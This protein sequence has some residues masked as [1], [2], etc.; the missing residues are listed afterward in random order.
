M[1][2]RIWT[3]RERRQASEGATSQSQEGASAR[4]GSVAH[5]PIL[6]TDGADRNPLSTSGA[7]E[8]VPTVASGREARPL[9]TRT[10]SRDPRESARV[11]LLRALDHWF[12][13]ES[14]AKPMTI[15]ELTT[16]EVAAPGAS[17]GA[18]LAELPSRDVDVLDF[19]CGSGGEAIWL[20]PKLRSVV[21]VDTK[22]SN[23]QQARR[24]VSRARLSNCTFQLMKDDCIP[25]PDASVDAVFS[26]GAF[27][28]VM[29][30]R[31]AFSEIARVLRPGGILATKFGPL[32]YSPYGYHM[33]W[34]CRVPYAHLLFG[35]DPVMTLG[36]ERTGQL[37]D[38][39]D[40]RET[41][42]NCCR[43]A[44]FR[45]AAL[46]S[47]LELRRFD[48]IP[49]LGVRPLTRV[50]VLRDL[51]IFGIDCVLRRP[52]RTT[53]AGVDVAPVEKVTS[54]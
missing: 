53:G 31:L 22:R 17:A 8:N 13:G 23:I 25:L 42:L 29:D 52:V 7:T 18:Y 38:V 40:W 9:Y 3:A 16:H 34:A 43:F 47:G 21:G 48:A 46:A 35:L 2:E 19:W 44:D 6:P 12:R 27:E 36:R 24:A 26:T 32:F 11:R 51:F 28:H 4:T 5:A 37:L 14:H 10:A 45:R 39:Q 41:G 20:A 15:E 33:Q 50:P 30:L 1:S 49:V 54:V